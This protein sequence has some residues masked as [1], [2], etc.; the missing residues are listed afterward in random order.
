MTSAAGERVQTSDVHSLV[1]EALGDYDDFSLLPRS[2]ARHV[3]LIPRRGGLLL[4]HNAGEAIKS[5][6]LVVMCG[7]LLATHKTIQT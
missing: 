4:P 3:G 7:W 2:T 5:P 6:A 1:V